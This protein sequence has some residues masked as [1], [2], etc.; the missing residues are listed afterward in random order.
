MADTIATNRTEQQSWLVAVLLMCCPLL[1][2]T[3][4]GMLAPLLVDLAR[5]FQSTVPA[6]GQLAAATS[7]AWALAAPALSP[8]SDRYGR[9]PL[10]LVGLG[11]LGLMTA[12]ASLA[13][14]LAL[15]FGLRFLAGLGGGALG[16][17]VNAAV[18]DYFPPSQRAQAFGLVMAGFSFG[19][20][21]GVP[22]VAVLAALLGWRLTFLAIGALL[23]AL[24]IVVAALLPP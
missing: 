17:S 8:L 11:V 12:G 19:A 14:D 1:Y 9:K 5:D 22:L 7:L 20:L 23:L 2:S 15:L 4:T 18:V 6:V 3:T 21:L 10:M 13:P 24:A 16:P